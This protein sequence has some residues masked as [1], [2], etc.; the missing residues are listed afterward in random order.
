[1]V[2]LKNYIIVSNIVVTLYHSSIIKQLAYFQLFL[3][4]NNTVMKCSLV[5]ILLSDYAIVQLFLQDKF[6]K[7]C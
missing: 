5:T 2:I 7:V 3:N 1:M 6:L 4:I